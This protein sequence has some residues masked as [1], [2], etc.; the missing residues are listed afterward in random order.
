MKAKEYLQ[1]A[2]VLKRR[3]KVELEKVEE[4]MSVLEYRSPSFENVGSFGSGNN[5]K[6]ADTVAKVIDY[7]QKYEAL[8]AE[9]VDKYREIERVINE[10]DDISEREILERRYLLCEAWESRYD[11]KTGEYVVGIAEKMGYSIR[12]AYQKHGIALTK[13]KIPE[14]SKINNKCV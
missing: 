4:L 7:R 13:I 12:R 8:R 14:N 2:F 1:Q 5:S 10:L 9:Y 3:M 11:E 6:M